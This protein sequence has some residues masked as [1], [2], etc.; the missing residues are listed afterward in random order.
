MGCRPKIAIA[1][2]PKRQNVKTGEVERRG[3]NVVRGK[4]EVVR[5]NHEVVR[6]NH[7]VVRGN[8]DVLRERN[9]KRNVV[10]K[11]VVTPTKEKNVTKTI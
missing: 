2:I 6:G 10:K 4:H 1:I 5:G 3:E 9:A 7:D 8:H 11:C